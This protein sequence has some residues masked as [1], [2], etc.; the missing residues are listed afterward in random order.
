MP[1]QN[2]PSVSDTA[3]LKGQGRKAW[4]R[5]KRHGITGEISPQQAQSVRDAI[6]QDGRLT[7]RF[8]LM[9]ALSGGIAIL[10]LL[11]SSG[12]VVIG[13]MLVSPM[14]GPIAALGFGFA[15]FDGK[16][17][18]DAARV[19]LVGAVIGVAVGAGLTLLSPIRNSTPE[20]VARTAPNLLDL[21]VA[22]LSGVAGGYAT[23]HQKGEAAIGVAIATALMPPL[24]TVGYAIATLR[25]DFALGAGLLFLTNLA[26]ISFSF[27]LVARLFGAAR[28]L[29]NVE[30]RLRYILLGTVAFAVLATPLTLTLRRVSLEAFATAAARREI[31]SVLQINPSAIAELSVSWPMLST[32]QIDAMAVTPHYRDDAEA[33]V[34]SRLRRIF[35]SKPELSLRQIV[36]ATEGPL[37]QSMVDDA[38]KREVALG[39]A[40]V[41]RQIT[42]STAANTPPVEK[43]RAASRLPITAAWADVQSRTIFLSAS[44]LQEQPLSRYR[45]EETRLNSVD[46]GWHVALV[47]PFRDRL[48]VPFDSQSPDIGEDGRAAVSDISWALQRWAVKQVTLIGVAGRNSRATDRSRALAS[49]RSTA[50]AEALRDAHF[51]TSVSIADRA[52]GDTLFRDGG[53]ARLAGVEIRADAAP[54]D[55]IKQ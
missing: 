30:F 21:A 51:T 45:E 6:E 19:V 27:A 50:V 13:A 48:F 20:I 37:T 28:P 11:Q 35:N 26:A 32:L 23:V 22:L 36:A 29:G 14:M 24:A 15:S 53:A 54:D 43:M 10:G 52:L 46:A 42:A 41:E 2:S 34:A 5:W 40:A 47:P 55:S 8:A 39:A 44:N 18:Q 1:A 7:Q 12:A 17:V 25:M 33:Q 38:V 3:G 9:C 31:S 16:R 49:S 4:L